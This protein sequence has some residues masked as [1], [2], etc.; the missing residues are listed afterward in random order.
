MKTP[1]TFQEYLQDKHAEEYMGFD[2]DMPDAFDAW[3]CDLEI[4][5]V[6][7]YAQEWH[8]KIMGEI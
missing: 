1:S 7:E 3:L 5:Y 6:I 2:D 8:E 4:D